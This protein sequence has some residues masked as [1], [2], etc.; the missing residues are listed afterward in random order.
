MLGNSVRAASYMVSF[1]HQ[2]PNLNHVSSTT[3]TSSS[4]SCELQAIAHALRAA[5]GLGL[6]KLSLFSDS[7]SAIKIANLATLAGIYQS[8]DLTCLA[9]GNSLFKKVFNSL[10]ECDQ[11]FDVLSLLYIRVH[12]QIVNS[13]SATN[14]L[15]DSL[16]KEESKSALLQKLPSNASSPKMSEIS[17]PLQLAQTFN[18]PSLTF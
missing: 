10:F 11:K 14:D 8:R 1:G 15:C 17:V 2:G 3:D 9:H 13:V 4:T 7:S 16:A 6:T 5:S 12:Q 18:T